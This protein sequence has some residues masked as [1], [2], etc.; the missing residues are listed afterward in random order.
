MGRANSSEAQIAAVADRFP[1]SDI[2]LIG[3]RAIKRNLLI[4]SGEAEDRIR[5]LEMDSVRQA[6]PPP[7]PP[8]APLQ[9]KL[10]NLLI[11]K[12]G[13]ESTA[14]KRWR[15]IYG[16]Q[17]HNNAGLRQ[18]DKFAHLRT[19]L[20]GEP[21]LIVD[22]IPFDALGYDM[23]ISV[24]DR[25]YAL[26]DREP[27]DLF[28]S[29]QGLENVDSLATAK[30]FGLEMDILCRKMTQMGTDTNNCV[31]LAAM[32]EKLD[33]YWKERVFALKNDCRNLKRHIYVK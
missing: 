10:P 26:K 14:F 24:L 11:P 29:L 12:F 2:K 18:E 17:I 1:A 23:A 31:I 13:G 6:N 33:R 28:K 22:E 16:S 20:E 27:K 9:V 8:A 3:K 5:Q 4:K 32:E 15:E 21:L 7:P 30:K 25:K 19:L